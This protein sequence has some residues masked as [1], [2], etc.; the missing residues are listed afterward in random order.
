LRFHSFCTGTSGPA[1]S[2]IDIALTIGE[3]IPVVDTM[4]KTFR[5]IIEQLEY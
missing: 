5:L 3:G 4:L 2:L 1:L